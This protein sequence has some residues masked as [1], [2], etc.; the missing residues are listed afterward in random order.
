MLGKFAQEAVAALLRFSKS[1]S[2]PAVAAALIDKAAEIKD[3][4]DHP[5]H[6]QQEPMGSR[7]RPR[8]LAGSERRA[9]EKILRRVDARAP[10]G[11]F[12]VI[13]CE[14]LEPFALWNLVEF[15]PIV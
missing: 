2:D 9:S 7:R 4:A 14:W 13:Q 3:R 15:R 5:S 10:A 11:A 8:D 6:N 12:L 1:T